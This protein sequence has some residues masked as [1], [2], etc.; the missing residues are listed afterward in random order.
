MNEPSLAGLAALYADSEPIRAEPIC[1]DRMHRCRCGL[2]P[3]HEGA[4]ECVDP[5]PQCGGCW[6]DH[7]TDRHQAIVIRYPG[8]RG[9]PTADMDLEL[10]IG[11]AAEPRDDIIRMPRGAIQYIAPPS[12]GIPGFDL[13]PSQ[14]QPPT[15]GST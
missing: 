11:P 6:M 1:N 3:D 8:R 5:D 2:P 12:L 9:G 4:H 15:K 13:P 10:P 14:P 7:P